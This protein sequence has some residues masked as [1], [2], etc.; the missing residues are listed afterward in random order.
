MLTFSNKCIC[1][2]K[3]AKKINMLLENMSNCY[4]AHSGIDPDKHL[5]LDSLIRGQRY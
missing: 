3:M 5:H 1:I 4:A 2:E